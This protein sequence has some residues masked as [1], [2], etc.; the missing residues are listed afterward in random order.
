MAFT[1]ISIGFGLAAGVRPAMW[2][3]LMASL[4]ISGA[5]CILLSRRTS[6]RADAPRARLSTLLFAGVTGLALMV[7]LN[8]HLFRHLP[9]WPF[10]AVSQ[11]RQW[12]AEVFTLTQGRLL[13]SLDLPASYQAAW[14]IASTPWIFI[15]LSL[16]G[17]IF[18]VS[19]FRNQL[20][21]LFPLVF[22]ALALP[23]A[24]VVLRGTDYDG[25]RHHLYVYPAL[26]TLAA[27]AWFVIGNT[28]HR[29][30]HS[31]WAIVVV[32]IL[33]AGAL[34][35]SAISTRL[36]WPYTYS[37]VNPMAVNG[38]KVSEEWETDYFG[39]GLREAIAT[40]PKDSP[41]RAWGPYE[42]VYPYEHLQG[43]QDTIDGKLTPEYW[44]IKQNRLEGY[45]PVPSGCEKA[46]SIARYLF[47]KEYTIAR[48]YSCA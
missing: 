7:L 3:V 28:N 31:V 46:S 12:H 38:E 10:V 32:A 35:E 23:V 2:G 21:I 33:T 42:S 17:L 26:A 27:L 14:F 4:V 40:T 24:F 16:L 29:P 11:N 39:V 22:Q 47:G 18:S 30:Q 34:L 15:V 5:L 45:V 20:Q 13:S 48:I 37:Y 19:F 6:V 41:F 8:P 1:L 36:L 43:S 9:G 44:W 25:F